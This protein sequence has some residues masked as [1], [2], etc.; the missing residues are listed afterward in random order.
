MQPVTRPETVLYCSNTSCK[1]S[2]EAWRFAARGG[3]DVEYTCPKCKAVAGLTAPVADEQ[4]IL[5]PK[6]ANVNRRRVMDFIVVDLER[7]TI[8]VIPEDRVKD[9]GDNVDLLIPMVT[10]EEADNL[11]R[12]AARDFDASMDTM[13]QNLKGGTLPYDAAIDNWLRSFGIQLFED[14]NDFDEAADDEEFIDDYPEDQILDAEELGV[15]PGPV[16]LNGSEFLAGFQTGVSFALSN[17]NMFIPMPQQ[18]QEPAEEEEPAPAGIVNT[19]TTPRGKAKA[20]K[21]LRMLKTAK[22]RPDKAPPTRKPVRR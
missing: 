16:A 4:P 3:D 17:L 1:F 21:L 14:A 13:I 11:Q 18:Q 12:R 9:E 15:M 2:D 22:A 10:P 8:K 5:E 6:E 19:R 20:L 7:R